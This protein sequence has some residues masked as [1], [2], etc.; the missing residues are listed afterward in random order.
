MNFQKIKKDFDKVLSYSQNILEPQTD[1]LFYHWK[2]N[3]L[4][5]FWNLFKDTENG[6]IEFPIE[7]EFDYNKEYLDRRLHQF[8]REIEVF[9]YQLFSFLYDNREGFFDNAVLKGY[10]DDYVTI[11]KGAKLVKS[12]KYFVTNKETLRTLQDK[13][14]MLIQETKIKGKLC[15]SINPLDF[16]SVSA[17][18]AGWRSCHSLDG[19]YRA[20]NLAYMTDKSTL[21]AYLKSDEDTKIEGF[22]NNVLWN[23][24]KWRMLVFISNSDNMMFAGR[25]YPFDLGEAAL[26]KVSE[27][28]AMNQNYA[29][30]C[31]GPWTNGYLSEIEVPGY[32][33]RKLNCNMLLGAK[34]SLV[35]ITDLM[36][37]SYKNQ[38]FYNDL[39]FSSEYL[40]PYYRHRNGIWSGKPISW[41]SQE[42]EYFSIGGPSIKCINCGKNEIVPGD[43]DGTML[44]KSCAEEL[45]LDDDID[46]E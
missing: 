33:T 29:H 25:Q 19:D 26:N 40:K 1:E 36:P 10:K 15:L 20:G 12:F 42:N 14:S 35:S 39:V 11:P 2:G 8:I 44:C 37:D 21:I 43:C 30:E 27:L 5:R 7:V 23:S 16:L 45:C 32:G 9:N 31:W 18:A 4:G 34:E 6:I 3:K 13:A 46:E 28:L 22:P 24:K 41:T 17:N 38:L